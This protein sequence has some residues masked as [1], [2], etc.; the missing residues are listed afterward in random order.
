MTRWFLVFL[1]GLFC[2]TAQAQTSGGSVTPEGAITPGNCTKFGTS[3]F[4]VADAGGTCVTSG[5]FAGFATPTALVSL[6][7]VSGSAITAMRSDAAPALSP[8]IASGTIGSASVI[9]IITWNS[10]GQLIT[11]SSSA[12]SVTSGANPTA[13]VSLSAVNGSA[14]TFMRS[15]GAPALDQTAAFSFTGLGNTTLAATSVL[16][17]PDGTSGAPSLTFTSSTSR[18][19]YYN[20]GIIVGT[21]NSAIWAYDSN[22]LLVRNDKTFGWTSGAPDGT[23]IDLILG[24][25]AAATLRLGAANAASPVS[26]SV[27][28]Q[29]SR[30]GT[31][32][33]AAAGNLTIQPG[34]G[35]G[36]SLPSRILFQSP[37]ATAVSSTTAQSIGTG[38][39]INNGAASIGSATLTIS[40]NT[41][42]ITKVSSSLTA[43]GAQGG[44]IELVCGTNAGTAK[45]IIYAG[46]SLTPVTISDNIGL[47]VSGC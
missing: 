6:S 9:P 29:G 11:V 34:I 10:A 15:D 33:N 22:S 36:N 42:G 41:L 8:V 27:I 32:S 47:G 24:R 38:L 20:G 16:K 12:I 39:T 21:M 17:L 1:F 28:T 25:A 45:I 43:P 4:K 26:Q 23:A 13:L 46:T 18:G 44:K 37:L 31:D 2:T 19:F 30:A 40:P 14:A 5:T 3:K 35:T 7:V